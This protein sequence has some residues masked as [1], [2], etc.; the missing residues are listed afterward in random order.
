[1]NSKIKH[2]IDELLL[3]GFLVSYCKLETY[4]GKESKTIYFFDYIEDKEVQESFE[5]T[6]EDDVIETLQ[7][8]LSER[9]LENEFFN[10]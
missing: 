6:K 8:T 10:I 4:I 5:A 2:L 3:L 1:M 9:R 7:K